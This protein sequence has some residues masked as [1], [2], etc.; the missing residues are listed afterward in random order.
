MIH[1]Y[2]NDNK[3][4]SI[5]NFL[6]SFG[7]Y[8]FESITIGFLNGLFAHNQNNVNDRMLEFGHLPQA[9]Q[10]KIT[11]LMQRL[12]PL[13]LSVEIA[14]DCRVNQ[15]IDLLLSSARKSNQRL[16]AA[17]QNPE[18]INPIPLINYL[19]NAPR[20]SKKYTEIILFSWV[21]ALVVQAIIS[22]LIGVNNNSS[23]NDNRDPNMIEKLYSAMMLTFFTL[24]ITL[25]MHILEKGISEHTASN[26]V[27]HKLTTAYN[28]IT[29]TCTRPQNPRTH[30][31][32][33]QL[34]TRNNS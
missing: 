3:Q 16:I 1:N 9:L 27:G 33:M 5:N 6:I 21:V 15:L 29:T 32:E 18:N 24:P 11:D 10:N 31:I 12:A 13:H 2:F 7:T 14:P 4:A 19:W 17:N 26:E 28:C 30:D 22:W 23:N 34:L 20:L 25:L 8:V